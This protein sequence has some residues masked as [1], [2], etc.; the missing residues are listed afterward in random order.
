MGFQFR[1]VGA[2]ALIVASCLLGGASWA[3]ACEREAVS[4]RVEPSNPIIMPRYKPFDDGVIRTFDIELSND[5]RGECA[6]VLLFKH[7]T[8]AR[9]THDRSRLR[10]E[11]R[12]RSEVSKRNLL[13]GPG[14]NGASADAISVGPIA[15]GE[16]RRLTR[17]VAIPGGQVA[18][19]GL[20][21]TLRRPVAVEIYDPAAPGAPIASTS[22]FL[23]TVV[24]AQA[25]LSLAGVSAG[26]KLDFGSMETGEERNMVLTVRSNERYRIVVR[27]E[28]RG[29]LAHTVAEDWRVPYDLQFEN[30]SMS[31]ERPR[32]LYVG[33][34]SRTRRGDAY[35]FSISLGAA[36][37]MRAGEYRDE[38]EITIIQTP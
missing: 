21:R 6:P 15:P 35:P 19:A 13:V 20:Y 4:V 37:D 1:N 2:S 27:S 29:A 5:G 38:L 14:A 12:G 23:R 3:V 30:R 18:P 8:P 33:R 31:L 9:A 17:T 36:E 7:P 24:E 16:K 11:I 32:T 22:L 10:Y 25:V 28:N 26:H 34:P